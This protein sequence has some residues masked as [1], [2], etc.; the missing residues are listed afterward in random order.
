MIN[1]SDLFLVCFCRGVIRN[2]HVEERRCIGFYLILISVRKFRREELWR[3]NY[4][5]L[6][7]RLD[8]ASMYNMRISRMLFF[9]LK[10]GNEKGRLLRYGH[11]RVDL[12][13]N[14]VEDLSLI[15]I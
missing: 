6:S 10:K 13:R 7:F 12:F 11:D 8:N 14:K 9:Q 5:T 4:F 2:F 1:I 15:H 3:L